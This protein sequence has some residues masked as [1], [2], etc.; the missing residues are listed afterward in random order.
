M[1]N[2]TNSEL[3]AEVVEAAKHRTLGDERWCAAIDRA[4]REIAENPMLHWQGTSLLIQSSTSAEV[5]EANG[6]CQCP[7]YGFH[8]ACW[9]RAAFKLWKRYLE[10]LDRPAREDVAAVLVAPIRKVERVRG[11]QI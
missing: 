2:I 6:S 4:A 9:H 7:A 3:F 1:L 5:Y 8:K 10:A 11:F